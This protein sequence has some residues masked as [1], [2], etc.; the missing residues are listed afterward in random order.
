MNPPVTTQAKA[1]PAHY[2]IMTRELIIGYIIGGFFDPLDMGR[3]EERFYQ[4]VLSTAKAEGVDPGTSPKK[5][6]TYPWDAKPKSGATGKAITGKGPK[7][8]EKVTL[9]LY[10]TLLWQT[11]IAERK[12]LVANQVLTELNK[13]QTGK[14]TEA[15]VLDFL[16]KLPPTQ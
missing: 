8:H 16:S 11:Y 9:A 3:N 2:L 13:W 5:Q 1:V 14:V 15:Q 4:Q 12:Y 10:L 7:G 6:S